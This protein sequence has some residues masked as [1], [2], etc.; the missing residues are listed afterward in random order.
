MTHF[1][2]VGSEV[3]EVEVEERSS[4]MRFQVCFKCI[5]YCQAVI[6]K[7]FAAEC[8]LNTKNVIQRTVNKLPAADALSHEPGGARLDLCFQ[9]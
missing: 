6:K 4:I 5:L 8:S 9:P 1:K 7:V 3:S 2:R